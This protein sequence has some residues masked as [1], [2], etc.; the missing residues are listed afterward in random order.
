LDLKKRI[1]LFFINAVSRKIEKRVVYEIKKHTIP[2]IM[3]KFAKWY[4]SLPIGLIA[5]NRNGDII[6]LKNKAKTTSIDFEQ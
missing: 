5:I 6:E 1:F 2:V 3:I 4:I